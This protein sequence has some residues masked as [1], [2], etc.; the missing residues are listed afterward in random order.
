M[1][2]DAVWA[3]ADQLSVD[4]FLVGMN[5]NGTGTGQMGVS[6]EGLEVVPSR[7]DVCLTIRSEA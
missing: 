1:R 6:E 3:A 4:G 2:D 7:G 5:A